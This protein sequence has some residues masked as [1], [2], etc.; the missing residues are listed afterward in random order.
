MK[1]KLFRKNIKTIIEFKIIKIN[2]KIANFLKLLLN[3]KFAK[4]V[5]NN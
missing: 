1:F 5:K 2:F 3:I 4:Q